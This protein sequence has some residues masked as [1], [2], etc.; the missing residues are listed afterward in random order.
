M[1]DGDRLP[2]VFDGDN[3]SY[4]KKLYL[5]AINI[6]VYLV[7]TQGFAETKDPTNLLGDEVNYEKWNAEAKNTLFRG[8]CKEVFN[9]VRNHKDVH[10]LWSNICAL[11]EGTKSEREERYHI[12]IKNKFF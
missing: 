3:F 12:V 9:R 7:A 4:G 8:L 6:G 2:L 5:K 10:A 1:F 11:H